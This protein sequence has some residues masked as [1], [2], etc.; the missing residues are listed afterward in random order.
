M[1]FLETK[2][3]EN[4]SASSEF[5]YE[6]DFWTFTL[7][8]DIEGVN[9]DLENRELSDE[10]FILKELAVD[11]TFF[12]D[13]CA[14][15][16]GLHT[17]YKYLKTAFQLVPA[18]QKPRTLLLCNEW[19]TRTLYDSCHRIEYFEHPCV[20]MQRLRER[21]NIAMEG[22]SATLWL[23]RQ[24]M[25]ERTPSHRPIAN[26][27]QNIDV[28]H[29][30]LR[31]HPVTSV[32]LRTTIFPR[33]LGD[34]RVQWNYQDFDSPSRMSPF[35]RDNYTGFG[36]PDV[37]FSGIDMKELHISGKEEP[38]PQKHP[39]PALFDENDTYGYDQEAEEEE[40][41]EAAPSPTKRAKKALD[42]GDESD[43]PD[44]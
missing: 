20:R 25:T 1:S 33:T 6:K 11:L 37:E 2:R 3:Y 14:R 18:S 15:T 4:M 29:Q 41:Q 42:E 22:E 39:M 31:T 34:E 44:E 26:F 24:R 8:G 38:L 10:R 17:A 13:L 21:L 43:E 23:L 16:V 40:T 7:N 32:R 36:R 27:V 12:R 9:S 28:D 19:L 5:N 35:P 30:L